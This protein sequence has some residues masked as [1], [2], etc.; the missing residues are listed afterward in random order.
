MTAYEDLMNR[1]DL[2]EETAKRSGTCKQTWL[3]KAAEMRRIA[4]EMS[5][6]EAGKPLDDDTTVMNAISRIRPSIKWVDLTEKEIE[7]AR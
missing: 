4:G 5:A 1:A 2:L 6:E 3:N 7:Y